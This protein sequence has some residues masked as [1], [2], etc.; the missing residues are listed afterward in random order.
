MPRSG[1]DH[2]DVD[3]DASVKVTTKERRVGIDYALIDLS[4]NVL[5]YFSAPQPTSFKG[6][7]GGRGGA[8]EIPL[9][10]GDVV[11]VAI[12]EAQSGGLFIPS[13]A[14]SRPGNY[15]SLP[16][17]TI[18]RNG[19]ITIPY[20][21]RVPAAGRLK[22]TVEQDVEDRLASRA[23]EPQVVITTTTS[24]SSQVAVLGDVNNPQRIEISPA[25]ERVLDVISAAG[26][27]TTNNIETNVTLQRRGKTATVAYTTLLKNPAENIY[28]APDDTISIDHE[29]RT[30]L[31]LGA[32]GTS[33]RF[34]FEESD[35][36][37]GEAIAKAGGLRDD[38]AD[39][40]QVLLYRLVPKKT[41]AAMHVDATRFTGET[42]PVIIRANLRD[43]ATLFAVQ[44]FKM[45]DKDI[46][47]ISN[48][49]SVELVKFLDIVNSVSSTVSGVADDANDTRNAVNDLGN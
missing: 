28:V 11:Q 8:P 13:D 38:R 20:A 27:L 7:G 42:V 26:G 34:D 47:Y 19:T 9:G 36:T 33:G 2:K 4:K 15:I 29:R 14:G 5:S 3:R 48:S 49:D 1:P 16:E 31:M 41:V 32:A 37:L 23:I 44:Q 40:A 18:D 21:G 17:Q 35:L 12:F 43:P 25:G 45:E 30:Y 24:R 10:F 22:E 6:F 39:P 46:I